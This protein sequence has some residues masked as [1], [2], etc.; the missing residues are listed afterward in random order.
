MRPDTAEVAALCEWLRREAAATQK[1][2]VNAADPHGQRIT[3]AAADKL[4]RAAEVLTLLSK[5]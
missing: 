1:H 5:P 2:A 3:L 4:N